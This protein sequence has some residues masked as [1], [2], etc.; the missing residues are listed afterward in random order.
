MTSQISCVGSNYFGQLGIVRDQL[1][2]D[3]LPYIWSDLG[4]LNVESIADIQCGAHFTVVIDSDGKIHFT[5]N[6]NNF[7]FPRF[8]RVET[9][10]PLK[11]VQIACGRKHIIALL[12][13]GYVISWGAGYAGQ[14]GLGEDSSW[15]HP[16]LI[17]ALDPPRVGGPVTKVFAGGFHSGALIESRNLL[18]MWG[19]NRLGQCGVCGPNRNE[20]L[21]LDP[22]VVDL[23]NVSEAIENVVCGRSHSCLLTKEGRLIESPRN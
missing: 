11:C 15:D 13:G 12:T 4:S 14:L 20:A 6:L 7:I 17:H 10:L 3:G 21:I 1:V 9:S 8:F 5:G 16:R 19:S 22:T 2:S 23:T 18:F